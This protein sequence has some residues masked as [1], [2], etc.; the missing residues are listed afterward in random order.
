MSEFSMN[1]VQRSPS[2]QGWR[3]DSA[4]LAN[5]SL[6]ATDNFSACSSRKEPVPAAQA[7]FISK[8]TITPSFRAM[9][10]ES[11]PP[12]SKMVSTLGS[13]CTAARA[14]AVISF[15]TTSAPVKSAI[16]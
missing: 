9:N 8:S 2:R 13:M 12:I 14:W 15:L 16:M 6:M 4:R 7:L 3:A 10:F 11:W 1:T 5:S